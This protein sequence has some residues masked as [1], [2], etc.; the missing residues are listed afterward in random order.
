MLP[1][2]AARRVGSTSTKNSPPIRL[3]SPLA[4]D[5]CTQH[6][7]HAL[8]VC[9]VFFGLGQ[10]V[11]PSGKGLPFRIFQALQTRRLF[12]RKQVVFDLFDILFDARALGRRGGQR[13]QRR[14]LV[15]EVEFEFGDSR[16]IVE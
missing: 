7:G 4:V 13:S 10:R 14:L 5:F 3:L 8:L 1:Q 2:V 9:K 15:V 6:G 16:V 11:L 12:G